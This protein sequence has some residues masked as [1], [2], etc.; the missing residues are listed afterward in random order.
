MK[1][2]G[3]TLKKIKISKQKFSKC[4]RG[5]NSTLP[6]L[7][8]KNTSLAERL[9]SKLSLGSFLNETEVR[10]NNYLRYYVFSS[11]KILQ[12]VKRGFEL[13]NIID[14]NKHNISILNKQANND[15]FIKNRDFFNQEKNLINKKVP[16][17]TNIDI[18]I[19]IKK[20]KQSL[21][22]TTEE[23]KIERKM[24]N[25]MSANRRILDAKRFFDNELN[26]DN[27][28]INEKIELY[29]ECC[30]KN[31]RKD[32][33]V[34]NDVQMIHYR[35]IFVQ[36]FKEKPVPNLVEINKILFPQIFTSKANQKPKNTENFVN[37]YNCNSVRNIRNFNIFRKYSKSS[38][39]I[40]ND[41][42]NINNN[43]SKEKD[44]YNMIKRIA[45]KNKNSKIR[46]NIKY[47]EIGKLIDIKL[48]D[49]KDYDNIILSKKRPLNNNSNNN[50]I[51]NSNNNTN[52]NLN[53]NL[54]NNFINNFISIDLQ[55]KNNKIYKEFLL[56]KKEISEVK[57]KKFD[58][59]EIY[60]KKN[61]NIS[62]LFHKNNYIKFKR[63]N[64]M[65]YIMR[66]VSLTKNNL[67]KENKTDGCGINNNYYRRLNKNNSCGNIN[68][69]NNISK[70]NSENENEEFFVT[71]KFK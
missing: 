63:R 38:N 65:R 5:I 4:L 22:P 14:Q 62:Y 3:K 67:N 33:D 68:K 71:D 29:K 2:T 46:M 41:E 10:S 28:L 49:L 57:K 56:L 59:Q 15:C 43:I 45:N 11:D 25:S 34:Y 17:Q 40:N 58:I 16:E 51:N 35:K 48:P 24:T 19:L 9:N 53:N 20:I 12:K 47:N 18:P 27:N 6:E 32:I 42:L 30:N 26:N 66:S 44:S 50:S 31:K 36:P 64:F 8:S 1:L 23:T 54:N 70:I 69:N 37:I 39:D 55:H 21:N 52:N 13:S 7:L 60:D 61:K